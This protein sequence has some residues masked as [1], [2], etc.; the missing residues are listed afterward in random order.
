MSA[1]VAIA[2]LSHLQAK[3]FEI[4]TRDLEQNHEAD[5][6][7]PEPKRALGP[8][9]QKY[10]SKIEAIARLKNSKVLPLVLLDTYQ[11]LQDDYSR[12]VLLELFVQRVIGHERVKI[13]RNS[14]KYWQ[15]RSLARSLQTNRMPAK[16][17]RNMNFELPHFDLKE[18]GYDLNLFFAAIGIDF[19]FL[20]KQYEYSGVNPAIAAKTGDIV[21]DAGSCYGDTALYFSTK[22]GPAGKV[23]G[24]E[25]I[26]DNLEILRENLGLNPKYSSNIEIVER[27]V[28]ETSDKT[29]YVLNNGPGSQVS[30]RP[31]APGAAEVKT[32]SID[33]M[34]RDKNLPRVDFIKMD[35]EGAELAALKGALNTLGRFRPS[36]AIC[37][38]HKPNDWVEIPLFIH[39]LNLGY[40]M[41][42]DHFSIYPE[43]TVLFC[44]A[45]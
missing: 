10:Q 4:A 31:F 35:I 2:F 36:L 41:W 26:P 6:Y 42:L 28:W 30:E 13:F 1:E 22:V 25:F 18:I 38:Y 19:T 15:E 33:D 5:R 40:R 7:G 16:K 27:P 34:V 45:V 17:I 20:K 9:L 37:V 43:E 39:N 32:I 23:I 8:E 3:V 12:D 21:I 44:K 24:F 11:L 14:A 29:L